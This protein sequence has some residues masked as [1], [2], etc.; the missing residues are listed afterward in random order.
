LTASIEDLFHQFTRERQFI[1][2][3]SP[4]TLEA[5]AWAWKAFEPARAAREQVSKADVLQ[6]IEELRS[7]GLSPVSINTYLRSVNAFCRWL[8]TLFAVCDINQFMHLEH[9]TLVGV[10]P[11]KLRRLK[12]VTENFQNLQG[13]T[14]FVV[15]VNLLVISVESLLA[16]SWL[17]QLSLKAVQAASVVGMLR[18]PKYYQR[19]FGEVERRPMTH[20]ESIA[21]AGMFFIGIPMLLVGA[22]L[23]RPLG[24]F[25]GYICAQ[26]S[27]GL[28]PM[29]G[30]PNHLVNFMPSLF[31]L[32]LL[33]ASIAFRRNQQFDLRRTSFALGGTLVWTVIMVMPLQYPYLLNL[34]WWK[35]LNAGWFGISL[36]LTG[37]Y[38]HLT[39]IY[40]LPRASEIGH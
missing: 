34:T 40:L 13:L 16:Q 11:K 31:W 14:T 29:L 24:R 20:G 1:D 27:H 21:L 36:I 19:R 26:I 12:Y 8:W 39:L 23:S 17:I 28:H 37:I 10:T 3:V 5:Y 25:T 9:D 4:R 18:L 15:G 22:A 2:N 35:L 38:E 32:I 33:F 6:R 7:G 30:D